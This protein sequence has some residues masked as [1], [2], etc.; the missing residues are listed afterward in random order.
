[1]SQVPVKQEAVKTESPPTK[2][3]R[4][5]AILKFIGWLL[6]GVLGP[7]TPWFQPLFNFDLISTYYHPTLNPVASL[8]A[9]LTFGVAF[10]RYK[11]LSKDR[12]SKLLFLPFG[13]A[14]CFTFLGCFSLN[15]TIGETW[16]PGVVLGLFVRVLWTVLYLALFISL[17]GVLTV[18]GLLYVGKK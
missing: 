14:F 15:L 17:S 13:L 18:L 1:M 11:N 12:L 4:L 2:D 10:Q 7:M 6:I 8:L 5:V 16:D 3:R 9:A